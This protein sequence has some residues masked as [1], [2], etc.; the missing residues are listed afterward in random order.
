MVA[1]LVQEYPTNRFTY[2]LRN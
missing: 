1:L 2:W